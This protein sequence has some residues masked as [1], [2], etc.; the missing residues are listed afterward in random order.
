MHKLIRI[1]IAGMMLSLV[2][3][4]HSVAQ[5][6]ITLEDIFRNRIFMPE[7]VWGINHM[8]NGEQYST[9][10]YGPDGD[11]SIQ[12]TDY[13][14]GMQHEELFNTSWAEMDDNLF[15][16]D[17]YILSPDG[18]KIILATETEYIYR[19]SSK[20]VH[21]IWDADSKTM[22]KLT[23]GA[24]QMYPSFSPG[25]DKIAYVQENNLYYKDLLSGAITQITD[26]GKWNHIIN[27]ASD[28]VYEEELY[29]TKAFEWSPD[30]EMIAFFRFDESHVSEFDMAVYDGLYPSEY[31]F[32]Y[33]KVGEEN[34][35]VSIH[36]YHLGSKQLSKL[37]VAA[38]DTEYFPRMKWTRNPELL[39]VQRMNRHQNKL[40]LL[41]VNCRSGAVDILLSE[42]SD[43]YINVKDD[44]TF[45]EDG[46]HFIWT[47]E[48][49][50]YN[51]I[52]LFDMEGELEKQI[53]RGPWDVTEFLGVDEK[54]G[55]V[56]YISGEVSPLERHIY[57]VSLKGKKKK[58]LTNDEGTH[59]IG[60]SSNFKYGLHTYSSVT[61]PNV[62]SIVDENLHQMRVLKDNKSLAEK[63]EEY[64]INSKEFFDMPLKDGTSLNGWMIKPPDFDEKNEYPVLMFVYGGPGSQTV[65]NSWSGRN[66]LW[67]YYLAQQGYII[68]S[69]DNRGTGA[70]GE[71][72]KKMTYM[73]L[74]KYEVEDQIAAAE[75]LASLD[76]VA[77]GR[78]GIFGWSYGGY[79][80]SN[81]LFQAP[82][83]F[84]SAIAVAPVTHWK[85]Y[86]TIYTER[87]MRTYK[88]NEE[89][90]DDGSPIS[91]VDGLEGKFLLVHGTADDNVH[92]QNSVEL[93]AALIKAGKQFDSFYYPD[94]NHGISGRYTSIHLYTM[95]TNFLLENL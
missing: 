73:K 58:Q 49:D 60:F 72:F 76:Y 4:P 67:F 3:A 34:A 80:S 15:E 5:K 44:L 9:I 89:G 93:V 62:I 13:A 78:I 84:K 2:F 51:H 19:H 21:Y 25:S 10:E 75:Y 31:R 55:L 90:Y 35:K 23:D 40:E 68:A 74:G 65:R 36:T 57:S 42:T 46:E 20:A 30:G 61:T 11:Q 26:D 33:P 91:H 52:Y 48:Q 66:D 53:T 85:Y 12:T 41:L 56:Y 27:G 8:D 29:L 45:L 54:S 37:N 14:T 28:W 47:S 6:S 94:K 59:R 24:H 69:V 43:Y 64:G 1:V 18:K 32:K 22:E 79:M 92:F 82:E 70:R 77:A 88:E 17:S 83:V 38:N 7:Y 39:S 16:F 95:M 63:S 71:E 86:D 50:G 81:C 87:F